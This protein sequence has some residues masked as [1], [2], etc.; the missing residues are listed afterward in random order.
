VS[1][2]AILHPYTVSKKLNDIKDLAP[3]KNSFVRVHHTW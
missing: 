2:L 3:L 1:I